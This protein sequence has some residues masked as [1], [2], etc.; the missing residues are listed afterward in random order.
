M[1]KVTLPI[2][3]KPKPRAPDPQEPTAVIR[4]ALSSPPIVHR[5]T[6]P[7]Q[8]LSSPVQLKDVSL[9]TEVCEQTITSEHVLLDD[10]DSDSDE[11]EELS[12]EDLERHRLNGLM[13]MALAFPEGYDMPEE[14]RSLYPDHPTFQ[15]NASSSSTLNT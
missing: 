4:V 13:R 3:P 6:T 15:R 8:V 1:Q 2:R 12:P 14:F 5:V 9:D 11:S 7:P 10:T